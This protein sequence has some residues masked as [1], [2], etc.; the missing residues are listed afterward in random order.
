MSLAQDI[1]GDFYDAISAKLSPIQHLPPIEPSFPLAENSMMD[2]GI[3]GSLGY[4]DTNFLSMAGY[5]H[6]VS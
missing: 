5:I 4:L 3:L 6:I 1:S 2:L